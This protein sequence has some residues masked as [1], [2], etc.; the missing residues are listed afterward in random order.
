V[1][2]RA[3]APLTQRML[4]AASRTKSAGQLPRSALPV[5]TRTQR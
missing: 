3:R 4:P 1:P 2:R 5:T